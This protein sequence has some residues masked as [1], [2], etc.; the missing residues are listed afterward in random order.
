[1]TR[2]SAETLFA[3]VKACESDAEWVLTRLADPIT[4][5]SGRPTDVPAARRLIGHWLMH[6]SHQFHVLGHDTGDGRDDFTVPLHAEHMDHHRSYVADADYRVA[7]NSAI[8]AIRHGRASTIQLRPVKP[9]NGS[10]SLRSRLRRAILTR[11]SGGGEVLITQPYLRFGIRDTRRFIGHSSS[12]SQWQDLSCTS[13]ATP[14]IER[15]RALARAVDIRDERSALLV[16]AILL[17]PSAVIEGRREILAQLDRALPMRPKMVFSANGLQFVTAFQVL[18]A[19]AE[20]RGTRVGIQQHGGH[21]GL[22]SVHAGENVEVAA[23]D[24]F[25][26]FGWVDDRSNVRPLPTA[27]PLR[28]DSADRRRMLVMSVEASDSIY[29]LQPFCLPEHAQACFAMT[30]T[31]LDELGDS[32]GFNPVVRAGEREHALIGAPVPRDDLRT[33]GT[34]SASASGLVV[35]NYLG[36]SWLETLAMNVPTLCIVPPN[37]HAFRAAAQPHVDALKAHG[38]IHDDP[39]AA[40]RFVRSLGGD[41]RAWWRQEDL[42]ADRARFVA[43]YA[44]YS[45]D[46]LDLWREEL[47]GFAE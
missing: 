17:M 14:L 10:I 41:A 15:R 30:R 35:H 42:Q 47:T 5:L 36:T 3:A 37:I 45:D 7:L 34:V 11:V 28:A 44:N 2:W 26:T 13:A 23:A 21:F 27:S 33:P 9:R 39:R 20:S 12:W 32:A 19:E 40:A 1:M 18:A 16:L 31:F 24:R 46:W 25:Y 29:R 8:A 22:D 43:T 38:V 6:V 4:E